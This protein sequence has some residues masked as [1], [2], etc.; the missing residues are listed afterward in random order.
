MRSFSQL[1][2]RLEQR[3]MCLSA[4][5]C[6]AWALAAGASVLFLLESTFALLR[7][8]LPPLVVILIAS[9]TGLASFA[10]FLSRRRIPF[11]RE[12]LLLEV[13]LRLQ[14]DARLS[15]IHEVQTRGGSAA[16][17]DRLFRDVE[18]LSPDW[19][20]AIPVQKVL[21]V[22]P[23]AS[24]LLVAAAFA[25]G[26]VASH[27]ASTSSPRSAS[28]VSSPEEAPGEATPTSA[29]PA[30]TQPE[31]ESDTSASPT[32]GAANAQRSL[33]EIL[34]QLRP[35]LASAAG[36]PSDAQTEDAAVVIR[37]ELEQLRTRL[38][39]DDRPLSPQEIATLH[40]A[41]VASPDLA[42][43]VN[44]A[45]T[46]SDLSALRQAISRILTSSASTPTVSAGNPPAQTAP[47]TSGSQDV[48]QATGPT[49]TPP[50]ATA[51]NPSLPGAS[52][53]EEA[54]PGT[55][56]TPS[57]DDS[58]LTPAAQVT[59]VSAPL[60]V[61]DAGAVSSY[62]T[63]GV[64]VEEASSPSGGQAIWVISPNQVSSLLSSRDLPN[65]DADIIR[66]YFQRITEENP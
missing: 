17:A 46:V 10:A 50:Q 38:E 30:S 5:T 39:Q 42:K 25:I 9:S 3:K 7:R 15:S 26:A 36:A 12:R 22:L 37:R 2:A 48:A 11:A 52:D 24:L 60:T 58:N 65:G 23:M 51:P 61:G 45:V 59:P 35:A 13:D 40:D 33:S 53:S 64:P 41:T 27:F 49:T 44:D 66:D 21:R 6:S 1:A 62:V 28:A 19:S 57:P 31:A 14:L 29:T 16:F 32:V 43:A 47:P 18:R 54:P 34:S 8:S 56:S 20:R 55:P 4:L 63:Q